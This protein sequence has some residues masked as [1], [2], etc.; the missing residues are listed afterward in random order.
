M[1]TGCRWSEQGVCGARPPPHSFLPDHVQRPLARF[2]TQ[3]ASPSP[4]LVLGSTPWKTGP[5]IEGAGRASLDFSKLQGGPDGSGGQLQPS[6]CWWGKE[7]LYAGLAP[8]GPFCLPTHPTPWP[9]VGLTAGRGSPGWED[10]PLCP[11]S[12][13]SHP[14]LPLPTSAHSLLS[15]PQVL[16]STLQ[17]LR[18]LG[19]GRLVAAQ[20][21]QARRGG[22]FQTRT[23]KALKS[24]SSGVTHFPI[25]QLSPRTD[26]CSLVVD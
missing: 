7:P 22:R 8:V 17:P 1:S 19:L 25:L 5:A 26:R 2:C 13:F 18:Q 20:G 4:P 21:T 14:F 6:H 16:S 11:S 15:R 9:Q 10:P 3:M 23:L 24:G 12:G